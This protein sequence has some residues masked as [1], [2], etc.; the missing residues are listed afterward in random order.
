MENAVSKFENRIWLRTLAL[1]LVV[2]IIFSMYLG[3]DWTGH[4]QYSR[5]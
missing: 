5:A 1:V 4:G 2:L 3:M